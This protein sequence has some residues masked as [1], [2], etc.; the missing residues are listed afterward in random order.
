MRS[1]RKELALL[2][3]K[4][5]EETLSLWVQAFGKGDPKRAAQYAQGVSLLIGGPGEGA[6]HFGHLSPN[7]RK[8]YAYAIT[9]FFEWVAAKHGR[10]VAP[11]DVTRK[12]AEDYV[13][14]L[15]NRPY[16]LAKEKLKDGDRKAELEV[17]K[18]VQELGKAKLKDIES[19][20]GPALRKEYSLDTDEP[21]RQAFSKFVRKLVLLDVLDASP[22]ICQLREDFPQA[23]ITQWK[24]PTKSGKRIPIEDVYT[25]KVRFYEE[26]SR[27]TIAQR[28]SALSSLWKVYMQGDNRDEPL[29]RFNVWNIVKDRVN[30]NL[31]DYK[32]Q[33]SRQQKV[34]AELIIQIIKNLPQKS[35]VDLR[36]K[37][38]YYLMFFA[39]LRTTE[40]LELRRSR[41]E[42]KQ[43][44]AWFDG[45]EP[46]ALQLF[47]KGGKH[48]RMPY[49]PAALK[50]LIEFQAELDRRA[51]PTFAQSLDPNKDHY[52]PP[53]D[54]AWHYQKLQFPDAPL[55]PPLSFWGKNQNRDYRKPLSR[56]AFS[57]IITGLAA[58]SGL[59]KEE[60]KKVH[61][62]AIR[63]F[64][65]NAMV[66]GGKNIRDVQ[67]I[68]GHT[69]LVTTESYLEDVTE[70]VRLSGQDAINR[71]MMEKGVFDE[72][73]LPT[74]RE[75][76]VDTVAFDVDEDDPTETTEVTDAEVAV[77]NQLHERL[78]E[79]KLPISP[80]Y[81]P[82][83]TAMATDAGIVVETEGQIIGLDDDPSKEK[84]L[85]D[86]RS[87]IRAGKSPGSP[88]WVYEAM[89]DP[90]ATRETVVFNRGGERDIE[91]LKSNYPK[92]PVN[93][94]V[95]HQSLLPWYVKASGNI[96]RS[97]YFKGRAPFPIMSPDQVN[98]ETSVGVKFL[99][100]VE[101]QYSK[102]VHGDPDQG[103][104]PSPLR[105]I[106]IIRWYSFFAYQTQKLQ[107]HLNQFF[108]E[109]VPLWHP[110]NTVVPI[111]DFRAHSDQWLLQ[112]LS[113]N[114]HTYRAS[115]D[116][117][118]RGVK[119]TEK[120][121]TDSFLKSSFEGIE[122]VTKMPEWMIYDDPVKALFDENPAQWREMVKWLKNVTGQVLEPGREVDRESQ[123]EFADEELKMRARNIRDLL[124]SVAKL[125]D[126]LTKAK[127]MK[128]EKV[129]EYRAML[130]QELILYALVASGE[131]R[132]R[133]TQ[134][135]LTAMST[136]EFNSAMDEEYSRLG[137][138]NPNTKKY[139]GKEKIS[140]IVSELFP[141]LPVLD[142]SNIFGESDLFNP[143][144]FR[145]DE[146]NKTIA[147]DED[148]RDR[149]I[150]QFG[151]DPELI[152]RRATRAMWESKKK[153]YEAL[154]GV[155]MSYFSWIIPPGKEMQSQVTGIPVPE[156]GEAKL[157]LEARKNWLKHFLNKVKALASGRE[158]EEPAWKKALREMDEA[159]GQDAFDH[160]ADI[161][162]D[163]VS[164]SSIQ[165][166]TQ[167]A[168]TMSLL[169]AEE[170][171]IYQPNVKHK[172]LRNGRGQ[173]FVLSGERPKG[174]YTVDLFGD[175]KGHYKPNAPPLFMS[176]GAVYLTQKKTFAVRQLLPSPFRMVS[177]I[178][179]L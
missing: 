115:I 168:E 104:L 121:L 157:D 15:A 24:L 47:R 32:K 18:I 40:L 57:Q 172:M 125:V 117:M 144:W 42:G 100:S 11:E 163:F 84:A 19:R 152:V 107:D 54:I 53:W 85:E 167:D 87:T 75:E 3:G 94:G 102:F 51:A 61:P 138:P 96:T 111:G 69:S 70:D 13:Q 112:W 4:R 97:G 20:V 17:F 103:M 156:L 77:I 82:P 63:H 165:E 86:L 29:L 160:L 113:D 92:L 124:I 35:L 14:W 149:L 88:D 79:N 41:P 139:R 135:S 1:N 178:E 136:K 37:A 137:I 170:E 49:P 6:D 150:Q 175:R 109:A 155:M 173:Y 76:V 55:F 27:T 78:P 44:K 80:D 123:L 38:M 72:E 171:G 153:D 60:C 71:Y 128:K 8:A 50:A 159:E 36:N 43:Y 106:G 122:L 64:A 147:I 66:E 164:S 34:P 179:Y 62:H 95:G 131:E 130:R 12:D 151:Q 114:A 148:E 65:A 22:T 81:D 90:K 134:E 25:Y 176:P 146:K 5:S 158:I 52:I 58:D 110:Y 141:E 48:M 7:T 9:E 67:A 177:A 74:P 56:M 145:I 127:I 161:S 105:S 133:Y 142:D 59:T 46:P 140:K 16:S 39:G 118:K 169:L 83:A 31:S 73:Q 99:E 108:R 132:L 174:M 119:R 101:Q 143:K 120:D 30:R 23:G 33:A 21:A 98:P 126:S 116:S 129:S 68:L 28:V 10:I 154:W 26:V 91:W 93:T 162:L 166:Y 2:R 89:A 45:T